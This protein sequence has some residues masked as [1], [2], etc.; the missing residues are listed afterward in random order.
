MATP[1]ALV[2][3]TLRPVPGRITVLLAPTRSCGRLRNFLPLLA[4][5]YSLSCIFSNAVTRC[6]ATSDTEP[7]QSG[8]SDPVGP[9]LCRMLDMTFREDLFYEVAGE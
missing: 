8:N 3:L 7:P 9:R 4:A 2:L 5:L 6:V 1:S